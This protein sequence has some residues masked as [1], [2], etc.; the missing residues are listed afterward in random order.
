MR[1]KK[2]LSA[3]LIG[4]VLAFGFCFNDVQTVSAA[5]QVAKTNTEFHSA[6][7]DSNIVRIRDGAGGL[8][9]LVEGKKYAAL[10]DTGVGVGNLKSY[11][12]RMTDKPIVVILTHAHVD[13]ASGTAQFD[14]VFMNKKD[15]FLYVQHT[16]MANRVGYVKACNPAWAET[17]TERNYQPED[18][19][20]RFNDMSEG[21]TF[22]LGGVHLDIYDLPGHTQGSSAVL[23][24]ENRA[25]LTGDGANMFTFLFSDETLGLTSYKESLIRL[26]NVT[27]G[28]YDKVYCS[29]GNGDLTVDYLDRLIEDCDIIL[30]GQDDKVP[31]DF[32]GSH[33]NIAFAIDPAH[34][35]IDAGI[36]NI[37]YNPN[38]IH[39]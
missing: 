16:M 21:T 15:R 18:D 7:I 34:N 23:I 37:V 5:V 31:F 6:K 39:E 24:R 30:S 13:H 35:R 26:R 14:D 9:Y 29:H 1:G 4:A 12:E 38:R 25:L 10:I 27:Q 28:K 2:I 20:S 32:M 11:V 8:M 22:D 33:A 19:P 3:L 17:L 36:G